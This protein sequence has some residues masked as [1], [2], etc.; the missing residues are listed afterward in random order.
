MLLHQCL[1][2]SYWTLFIQ[3]SILCRSQKKK[4]DAGTRSVPIISFCLPVCNVPATC[5][6]GSA[7][8]HIDTRRSAVPAPLQRL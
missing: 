5:R 2:S 8:A 3:C 4:A 7:A 1:R 6:A